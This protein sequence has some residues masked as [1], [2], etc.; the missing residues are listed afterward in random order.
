MKKR[1]ILL[2][3][4]LSFILCASTNAFCQTENLVTNPG[5]EQKGDNTLAAGWQTKTYRGTEVE[6]TLDEKVH[7]SGDLAFKA[8][9]AGGG[10]SA[11]LFPKKNIDQVPP[12]QTY[13]ISLWMKA[14]D[15]G[16]SPNFIAP[17]VRFNFRP[18]RI[19]PVPTIDLMTEMKGELE[20]KELSLTST[21]PANAEEII[22]Q[23]M[24]T[25]GTIWIDD[26][27]IT[28]VDGE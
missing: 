12:G 23:I 7:H 3:F 25:K 15:L 22:L 10:G 20:W 27:T 11:M 9:F 24:L 26:V 4:A 5:F 8:R 1:I 13:K 6:F 18:T 28:P 21:A 17:A 16:Y 14:Q 19:Q 2:L